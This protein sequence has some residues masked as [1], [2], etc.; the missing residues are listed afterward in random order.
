MEILV[1]NTNIYIYIL[2]IKVNYKRVVDGQ[3][4]DI[5]E[6]T[7]FIDLLLMSGVYRAAHLNIEE[8]WDEDGLSIFSLAMFYKRF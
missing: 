5:I 8:L 4:T 1:L 6:L 3:N 2:K 7:V